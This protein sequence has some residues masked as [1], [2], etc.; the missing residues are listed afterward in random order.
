MCQVAKRILDNHMCMTIYVIIMMY[1]LY[2]IY[3]WSVYIRVLTDIYNDII[4]VYDYIYVLLHTL[5]V[6]EMGKPMVLGTLILR[7]PHPIF[8]VYPH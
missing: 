6:P 5:G 1:I 7:S 3:M 2:Y 8:S 4:C